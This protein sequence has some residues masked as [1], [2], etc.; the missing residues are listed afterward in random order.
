MDFQLLFGMREVHVSEETFYS[1]QNVSIFS[2]HFNKVTY[3]GS[4]FYVPYLVLKD[5]LFFLMKSPPDET[6]T[7]GDPGN[8][9]VIINALTNM[10]DT[11]LYN[12]QSHGRFHCNIAHITHNRLDF[13]SAGSHA[14]CDFTAHCPGTLFKFWKSLH[15]GCVV[16]KNHT[17]AVLLE[18]TF[19][20]VP[21]ECRYD[22][23]GCSAAMDMEIADCAK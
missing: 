9:L 17:N 14:R 3:H 15:Q 13:G 1:Q 20:I 7:E 11:S 23:L 8:Q 5:V 16:C 10:V 6:F 21:A 4:H 2:H 18:S 12:E 22:E 19:S